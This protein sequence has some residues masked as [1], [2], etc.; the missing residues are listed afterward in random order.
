M[1]GIC[2]THG[3]INDACK[4]GVLVGRFQGESHVYDIEVDERIILKL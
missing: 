4:I 2:S 3:V 1:G